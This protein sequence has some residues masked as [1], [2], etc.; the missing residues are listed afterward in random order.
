[1]S[2]RARTLEHHTDR[3]HTT[4]VIERTENV[5]GITVHY[6]IQGSGEPL[7]LI[8]GVGSYLEAW[9]SV[10]ARLRD[11]FQILSFDLRGHGQ[12]SRPREQFFIDDFVKDTLAVADHVGMDR[13]H[14][15]GFSLG[16]LIAQKLALTS[17]HRLRRL[18]LLSTVAGRNPQEQAR[19]Q[20][21]L[22]TMQRE[23]SAH[24][25]T[26][27]FDTSLSRWLTE[28]FQAKHPDTITYLRK[29]NAEND[30]DC[31][32]TAYRVLA[33]TDFSDV[34]DQIA[35]P[36][37]VATGEEDQGSSPRMARLMSTRIPDAR[38]EIFK[39][40]R[41]SILI[42]APDLVAQSLRAFFSGECHDQ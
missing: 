16:G 14:L 40:M 3:P 18:A 41:H 6:K 10:A 24:H 21:R 34:I 42:E 9:D 32:V 30:P 37:L 15:A 8:H 13:F 28:D 2:S 27:H 39:G 36:T 29:R 35:V 4:T 19:V 7:V 22:A 11:R 23:D 25:G 1:M 31:Y 26:H 17:P 12:S 5:D 20:E 38:L 33:A